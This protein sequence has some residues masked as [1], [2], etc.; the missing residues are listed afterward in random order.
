MNLPSNEVLRLRTQLL[1]RREGEISGPV[2]DLAVCVVRLLGAEW[3]PADQAFKHDG[4][5]TPPIAALVVALAT[6]DL[7][8]DV[9]RCSDRGVSKLSARLAP[10]VDLVA[11]GHRKLDLVN[12]DRVAVLVDG[13]GTGVGHQL[14]V[15]CRSVFLGEAGRET[16]ISQLDVSASVQEDVVWFDVTVRLG[17]L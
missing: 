13:F 2:D 7:R 10:C 16:E 5:H 9:I 11:V 14:L 12:A 3:R 15:V 4:A 1:I 17:Q 8:C 6:E